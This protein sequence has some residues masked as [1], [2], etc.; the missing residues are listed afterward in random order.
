ML[1][2]IVGEDE[3]GTVRKPRFFALSSLALETMDDYRL[4]GDLMIQRQ[5]DLESALYR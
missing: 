5:A 3:R 1:D 2:R 4:N